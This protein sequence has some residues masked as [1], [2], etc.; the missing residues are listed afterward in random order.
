MAN[1]HVGGELL[2]RAS[3]DRQLVL[4]ASALA[5]RESRQSQTKPDF[6]KG[7]NLADLLWFVVV[8][9]N[10]VVMECRIHRKG[11]LINAEKV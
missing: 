3:S 7:S 10:Q 8:E 9:Q 11:S 2:P 1:H 5:E 4:E 6:R